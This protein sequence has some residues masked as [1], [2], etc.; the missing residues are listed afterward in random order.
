MLPA[1]SR[2]ELRPRRVIP[3][4]S[5]TDAIVW[6]VGWRGVDGSSSPAPPHPQTC[7]MYC[8]SD[9]TISREHA[10]RVETPPMKRS[11]VVHVACVGRVWAECSR[12]RDRVFRPL[13]N[14]LFPPFLL[15]LL[16]WVVPTRSRSV[17]ES[18]LDRGPRAP[19]H[20][21]DGDDTVSSVAHAGAA[22]D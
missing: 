22:T 19:H 6:F 9:S 5:V 14:E 17:L 12:G 15:A 11:F 16:Y 7:R 10:R 18:L 21:S 3:P 8:S 1:E 13:R 20:C 4:V 2:H